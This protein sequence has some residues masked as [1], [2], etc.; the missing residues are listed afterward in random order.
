MLHKSLSSGSSAMA[1]R[2]EAKAVSLR[3]EAWREQALIRAV[4]ASL[5]GF[6]KPG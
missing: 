2:R 3:S 4:L 6:A 5:A 1:Q